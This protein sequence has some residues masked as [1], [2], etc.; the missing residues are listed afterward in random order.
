LTLG[1]NCPI[2]RRSTLSRFP[3]YVGSCFVYAIWQAKQG[4]DHCVASRASDDLYHNIG[5]ELPVIRET[6]P[7]ASRTNADIESCP[8]C[9]FR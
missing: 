8:A 2:G 9:Q 7:S 5:F 1:S 6:S 4:D 3:G